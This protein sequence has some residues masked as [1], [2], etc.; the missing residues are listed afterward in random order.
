MIIRVCLKINF[1]PE[2]RHE[3]YNI[4]IIIIIIIIIVLLS[5]QI[6]KKNEKLIHVS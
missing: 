5:H 6:I 1:S 3:K 2:F 4:I